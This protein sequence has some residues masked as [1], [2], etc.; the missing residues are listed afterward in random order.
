VNSR[1]VSWRVSAILA[2]A[3]ILQILT[4]GFQS[5]PN[6]AAEALPT[7]P[8]EAL[9]RL[10]S[11]GEPI[12][13]G[14]VLTLW[15]QAFDNQPGVSIPYLALDYAKVEEWLDRLLG[16]DPVAQYP[17][18]MA[19]HLYGQVPDLDKER[20]MLAFIHRR[21]LEMPDRR[22]P[23]LAYAVIMAKHRVK[24]LPLA[25]QYAEDLA[26]RTSDPSVPHWAKQM[27]IFLLEDLGEVESAR[28]LLGGLLDSGQ[29]TD[30]HEKRLLIERFNAMQQGE[31]STALP[32]SRL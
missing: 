27:R 30:E 11:I 23:W 25:L 8:P 21:F 13:L 26:T 14:Q 28:I 19:A 16:L 1:N 31:K 17:L 24:D 2:C 29:I 32:R 10:S 9:L 3:L 18:L 12:A 22:W 5:R 20:Q 6:A 7:A 15:L 4:A